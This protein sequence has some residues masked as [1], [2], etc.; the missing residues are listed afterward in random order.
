[1]DFSASKT[2][3]R[4]ASARPKKTSIRRLGLDWIPPE[5]RENCGEIEAAAEAQR[6][7]AGAEQAI[8]AAISTC[9]R[10][11][12]DGRATLEEMAEAARALGYEYVAITD[13]SKALAMA[14]GLD[15]ARVVAFAQA[16]PRE[17]SG[18]PAGIR[19]FSGIE[20]DILKDGTMDFADDALAELDIVIGSVH[21]YMNLEPAEMTDRLLRALECPSLRVLG[22]LDRPAAAASRRR[23]SSISRRLRLKRRGEAFGSKLTRVRSVLISWATASNGERRKA[24]NSRSLPMRTIPSICTTCPMES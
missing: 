13:H 11:E 21:S 16:G 19:M 17:Q 20:C 3:E 23:I 8:F 1:M 7:R 14:N 6:C 12:T 5:L 2:N 9:I 24:A 22:H 10:R 18:W 4:V 15:E